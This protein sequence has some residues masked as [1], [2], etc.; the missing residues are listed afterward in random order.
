M[1]GL[2]WT[3]GSKRKLTTGATVLVMGI[4]FR[5]YRSLVVRRCTGRWRDSSLW[6][7][8]ILTFLRTMKG[9]LGPRK[10]AAVFSLFHEIWHM[11]AAEN[12]WL[13][14][15]QFMKMIYS[16]V[17]ILYKLHRKNLQHD[18]EHRKKWMQLGYAQG[19]RQHQGI[20]WLCH[21]VMY[22]C[23]PFACCHG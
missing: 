8:F 10:N 1:V 19:R 2:T 12:W 3:F 15:I 7:P 4:T 18:L 23:G 21:N 17:S 22:M 14:Y 6:T 13:S 20:I 9:R 11:P 5:S 16:G